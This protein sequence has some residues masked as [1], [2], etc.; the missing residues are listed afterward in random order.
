MASPNA[1]VSPPDD[2]VPPE[3]V[4]SPPADPPADNDIPVI[5][6]TG[7]P[8]NPANSRPANSRPANPRPSRPFS[9]HRT[10]YQHDFQDTYYVAPMPASSIPAI[11]KLNGKNYRTWSTNMEL[12]LR[13]HQVWS[14]IREPLPH[15]R[16]RSYA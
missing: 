7:N 8:A 10:D 13:R 6:I 3:D 12:V 14:L 11:T 4:E 2:N 5:P 15:P 1:T 9:L 16:E